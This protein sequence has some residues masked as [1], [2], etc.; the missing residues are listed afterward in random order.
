[1]TTENLP[2]EVMEFIEAFASIQNE[3]VLRQFE[4]TNRG[5]IQDLPSC[6]MKW[7]ETWQRVTGTPYFKAI[8]ETPIKSSL[9]GGSRVDPKSRNYKTLIRFKQIDWNKTLEQY[10][11]RKKGIVYALRGIPVEDD[12]YRSIIHKTSQNQLIKLVGEEI[13][14]RIIEDSKGTNFQG[15]ITHLGKGKDKT[16]LDIEVECWGYWEVLFAPASGKDDFREVVLQWEG[17]CL[18][19]QR[20]VPVILPGYYLEVNDNAT[21]PVY[22]QTPEQSRKITGYV[23]FFPCTVMREATEKEYFIMK[24]QGDRITREARRREEEAA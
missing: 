17:Q 18:Q 23:Q 11:R 15:S 3:A 7:N 13:S 16:P 5:R 21:Y 1:M 12:Q 2:L 9:A 14:E 19:I 4:H 8:T 6:W 22:T 20:N 24:K 10:G